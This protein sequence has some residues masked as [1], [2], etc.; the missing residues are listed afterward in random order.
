MLVAAAASAILFVVVLATMLQGRGTVTPSP[1]A[2]LPSASATGIL[3]T[4]STAAPTPVTGSSSSPI[5]SGGPFLVTASA[6]DIGTDIHL[7]A[8][9]DD[10]LYVSVP[11]RGAVLLALIGGDGAVR[12]GWPVRLP[13]GWCPTLLAVADGSVRVI[14]NIEP[15]DDGLSPPM[16]RLYAF[17]A[18]GTT[19]AGW[20]IERET[21]NAAR[22]VGTDLAMIVVPY[23]GDVPEPGVPETIRVD[24]AAADGTVRT[25]TEV[26]QLECCAG[27]WAIGPDGVAY[28]NATRDWDTAVRTDILAF[29]AGG[30]RPGWP[31]S[32]E[33]S[34]SEPAFDGQ[35]RIHAF[36]MTAD[37]ERRTLVLDAT[38]NLVG[39]MHDELPYSTNPWAGAGVDAPGPLLVTADG[40]SYVVGGEDG[41]QIMALDASS[42]P[43]PGWP[44]RSEAWMGQSGYCGEGDTGCG[45]A[46]VGPVLGAA[47]TLYVSL[48]AES[49]ATGSSIVAVGPDGRVVDGWP[50]GLRRPG[51]MFWALEPGREGV[52]ALAVEPEARGYSA[53][54]LSIAGDSTVRW[55]TTVVEP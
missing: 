30:I 18:A 37:S 20:P 15:P 52:F 42:Q 17:D 31:I 2:G 5:V 51:A 4:G 13:S 10:G 32:V 27:W 11:D 38:G 9:P 41:T 8:G 49:S 7:A 39:G 36:V 35:S 23:R 50:V 55:T 12:T 43:V 44:Y 19:L 16:S 45:K 34:A 1:I 54:I 53:T 25:G 26:P 47:N 40:R 29:D 3:P 46:R 14:C 22:M 6:R 24:V 48:A 28:I 33:G 21:A